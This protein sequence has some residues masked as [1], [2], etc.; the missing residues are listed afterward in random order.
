[1]CARG[2][3]VTFMLPLDSFKNVWRDEVDAF[4]IHMGSPIEEN[5]MHFLVDKYKDDPKIHVYHD[6][7]FHA[8]DE[9]RSFLIDQSKEDHFMLI[10]D[11]TCVFVKGQVDQAFKGIE[12]GRFDAIGTWSGGCSK[13]I[14]DRVNEKY[15]HCAFGPCYFFVPRKWIEKTDRWFMPRVF[16][17]GVHIKELDYTPPSDMSM[18]TFLWLSLQ[19]MYQGCKI[20]GQWGWECRAADIRHDSPWG[21]MNNQSGEVFS[22]FGDE[23]DMVPLGLRSP[24]RNNWISEDVFQAGK[25]HQFNLWK[26]QSADNWSMQVAWILNDLDI[27][28]NELE[29]IR[30]FRDL[31]KKYACEFAAKACDHSLGEYR[32]NYRSLIKWR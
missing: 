13:E 7:T 29:P 15:G 3:P 14:N 1:M 2:D 6:H 21:H 10:E 24:T 26:T 22:Y 4:Y 11:D 9:F 19:L 20:G 30:E 12:N 18:D 8:Y 31:Y 32:K 27:F 23:K 16:P 5:V 25:A 28:W 17:K